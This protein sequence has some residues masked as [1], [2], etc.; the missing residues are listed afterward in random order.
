MGPINVTVCK[1]FSSMTVG[2][3]FKK[4][5]NHVLRD[6]RELAEKVERS[7]DRSGGI[8][9]LKFE[10]RDFIKFTYIDC[11]NMVYPEYLLTK[12]GFTFL[13]MGYDDDNAIDFKLAY[14]Q[15]Y[16]EMEKYI[17]NR[18]S[19]GMTVAWNLGER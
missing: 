19:P 1:C 10:K 6:I 5:Q 15:R 12:D 17:D 3:E 11:R 14:I 16:N 2:D 4:E 13:V 8:S 18:T 9:L 7:E